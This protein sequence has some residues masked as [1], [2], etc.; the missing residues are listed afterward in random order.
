MMEEANSLDTHGLRRSHRHAVISLNNHASDDE[1]CSIKII[2]LYINW[3][4]LYYI[5][6]TLKL[7]FSVRKSSTFI[8]GLND[9]KEGF[10]RPRKEFTMQMNQF[11]MNQINL[12]W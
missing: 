3:F 6:K 9:G 1:V 2:I 10:Q 5:C 11:M 4:I 7:N 8:H 12:Y